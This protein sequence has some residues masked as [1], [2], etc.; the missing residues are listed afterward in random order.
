MQETKQIEKKEVED[1]VK[2]VDMS[3]EQLEQ[4]IK[5]EK[6]WAEKLGASE[7][8]FKTIEDEKKSIKRQEENITQKKAEYLESIKQNKK[9]IKESKNTIK[10]RENRIKED[11]EFEECRESHIKMLQEIKDKLSK[12]ADYYK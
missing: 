5:E 10:D 11:K 12:D 7:Y 4:E 1:G 6:E 2:Y 8:D 3:Q 9:W